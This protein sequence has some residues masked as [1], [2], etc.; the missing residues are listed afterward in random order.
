[1]PTSERVLLDYMSEE[2][3]SVSHVRGIVLANSIANLKQ[4]RVYDEYRE[5]MPPA[6]LEVVETAVASSWVDS[7]HVLAHHTACDLLGLSRTNFEE[8]GAA[9]AKRVAHTFLALFLRHAASWGVDS[10]KLSLRHMHRL[11]ER[12][13]R[14]G[15]CIVIERGPKE[16]YIEDHGLPFAGCRS[17]REGYVAFNQAIARLFRRAAYVNLARP[18][19]PHPHRIA[20]TLSWV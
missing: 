8:F 13:Y 17:Y 11:N 2:G 1:M 20:V 4:A 18:R 9:S 6:S 3:P 12:L 19:T 14:G 7:Q 5:R 15:G 10:I 16:I